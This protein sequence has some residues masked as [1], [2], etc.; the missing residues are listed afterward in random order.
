MVVIYSTSSYCPLQVR[1]AIHVASVEK[2]GGWRI[3]TNKIRYDADTTSLLP[4]SLLDLHSGA[5]LLL[6]IDQLRYIVTHCWVLSA[7]LKYMVT[8]FKCLQIYSRWL[9]KANKQESK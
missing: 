7:E 1:E 6:C 8:H 3:C 5:N 9:V 4:L 2:I